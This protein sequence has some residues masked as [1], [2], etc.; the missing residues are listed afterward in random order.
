MTRTHRRLLYFRSNRSIASVDWELGVILTARPTIQELD[1]NCSG[2]LVRT[3]SDKYVQNITTV[4]VNTWALVL[5]LTS[6][7]S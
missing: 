6:T 5:I 1:A 7:H 4:F 2:E 3:R